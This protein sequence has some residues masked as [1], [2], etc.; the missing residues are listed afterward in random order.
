MP[1]CIPP[2]GTFAPGPT[3]R[4]GQRSD[5]VGVIVIALEAVRPEI[6]HVVARDAKLGNQLFLQTKAS[7][8]SGNSHSHDL[9]FTLSGLRECAVLEGN[10]R[11]HS[12]PGLHGTGHGCTFQMSFAYSAMVRSLEN[13]PEAA[14]FRIALRV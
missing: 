14:M 5:I 7:V 10:H 12:V 4:Q 13:R 1:G 8:V 9:P 2:R 6:N 11:K 3:R